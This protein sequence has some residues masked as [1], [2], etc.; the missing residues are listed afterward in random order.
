V[1][2][3]GRLIV[4]GTGMNVGQMTAEAREW[5]MRADDV[6]YAVPDEATE[7][8][9]KTLSPKAES[10]FGFYD[11]GKPRAQTYTQ[12]VERT[13]AGVRAGRTVC[14]AFY[15]H[16]GVF[17]YPSHAAIRIARR[18]GHEARMLPGISA[19]DCLFADLGIDPARGIQ[20]YEATDLLLSRRPIDPMG[21][22][23]LWQ[24]GLIGD[25]TYRPEGKPSN[26]PVLAE[27][28]AAFYPADHP[29]FIYEADTEPGARPRIEKITVA[30]VATA[31][32]SLATTL[33]VPPLRQPDLDKAM[34][35][36]L[37]L[38]QSAV[39]EVLNLE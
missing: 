24:V 2:T 29:I 5:L 28:L 13:L 27:Y 10:L 6:V 34:V 1:T 21:R 39:D 26:Q 14:A 17:V 11:H 25:F 19:T 22:L 30:G 20:E 4:V 15:G 18:E 35:E 38:A 12:M 8:L 36:R 9:I 31:K 3:K 33:Y 7:Q 32:F 37:G 16:P 23:I